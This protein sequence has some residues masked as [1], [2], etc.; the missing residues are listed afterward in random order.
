MLLVPEQRRSRRVPERDPCERSEQNPYSAPDGTR[1][2]TGAGLSR[3]PLPFGLRGPTN[4]GPCDPSPALGSARR[5]RAGD[6]RSSAQLESGLGRQ[7][8]QITGGNAVIDDHLGI[9]SEVHR[10]H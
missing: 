9:R 3:L 4:R 2:H 5:L 8:G 1:T 7:F 6:W 10:L